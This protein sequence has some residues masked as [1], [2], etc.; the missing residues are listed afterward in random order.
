MGWRLARTQEPNLWKVVLDAPEKAKMPDKVYAFVAVYVDDI[1]VTGEDS[2]ARSTVR[3]FQDQWKCSSPEWL[4]QEHSLRFCGFEISKEPQG[5]RL[6]QNAY[7]KDLLARYSDLKPAS[8]PLPGRLDDSDE[9][10]PDIQEVRRAQTLV[11]ELLWLAVRTR[12]DIAYAVSWL[13]RHVARCPARVQKY[14]AQVLY[15]LHGAPDHGLLKTHH[16]EGDHGQGEDKGIHM[17]SDASF[18]PPGSRGHQGLMAM[19]SGDPVGK[20]TTTIRNRVKFRIGAYGV[21]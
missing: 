13:G 19:Y 11:G 2:V 16:S 7:L 1:L 3:R 10:N 6:H 20:Q 12:V 17:Y 15:F 8:S 4:T 5:I 18:G 9:P 14:G 21:F